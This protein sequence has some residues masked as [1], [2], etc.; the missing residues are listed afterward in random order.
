MKMIARY[1]TLPTLALAADAWNANRGRLLLSVVGVALGVALGVAV[2]LINGSAVGEFNAAARQLSGDADLSIRGPLGGFDESIYPRI[3]AMPEVDVASPAIELDLRIP[4][5]RAVHLLAV[6]PF[7]A[8]RIQPR[9]F[10]DRMMDMQRFLDPDAI[11]LSRAAADGLGASAGERITVQAGTTSFTMTIVAV[12][13]VDASSQRIAYA[14]IATAQWRLGRLGSIDRID[15]RLAPGADRR[16]VSARIASMLPPGVHVSGVDAEAQD[17][18]AMTRAYRINL[19][20]LA[21][22]ALFTG[23]FLVFATQALTILQ[24]RAEIAVLRVLGVTRGGIVRILVAES[25][26]VGAIGAALGIAIGSG[27]AWVA[28]TRFGGDLG[29]GYFSGVAIP[30]RWDPWVVALYFAL[31][32]G[33]SVAGCLLPARNAA[34]EPPAPA[35]KAADVTET[36][37]SRRPAW[38][39]LALLIIAGPLSMIPAVDD[40]PLGGYAA[41]AAVLSGAL[42]LVPFVSERLLAWLPGVRNAVAL[43]AIQQLR[44]VNNQLGIS[45]AAIV[46][47]F[48]L[49]AAM[50]I[51]IGS[52]R[53]SLERWLD[54]ILPADVYMRA[55]G[56]GQSGFIDPVALEQIA[57][58][59][60]V[61][62]WSAVRVR[63]I[64]VAADQLPLTVLA[65]DMNRALPA[66]IRGVERN[67]P[68]SNLP[69]AWITEAAADLHGW[70]PGSV[71]ELPL[72]NARVS[73]AVAG[74]WRDYTRQ[75]GAVLID[76]ARYLEATGDVRV[77]D[78]WIWLRSGKSPATLTAEVDAAFGGA[79]LVDI[80]D[81][82]TIRRFSLTMFDRTFAVTYVLEGVA[83]IIGLFGISVGFSS[84]VL[85]RRGEFGV[86]RYIGVTR[87]QIAMLLAIEGLIAGIVGIVYGL[88]TGGA[89]SV[90]LVHVINRQS[91]HWSMDMHVP[92][93]A[94]LALSAVL[95][96]A[97]T[98]TAV[99]S[100]RQAMT[101]Q[102]IAAVKDDW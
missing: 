11:L 59:P 50:L 18:V 27:L 44:G 23:S 38:P 69:P 48:S 83:V 7:Q 96:V 17:A 26:L 66:A 75:N 78:V 41:V 94:L 79:G 64:R 85:A 8:L 65:R 42:W 62:Q 37:A 47:S 10:G 30:L 29:A 74:I 54:D 86:L 28:L 93:G 70:K 31:G 95:V 55:G 77:N 32:I 90:L 82:A 98:V 49:M 25:A 63:E 46:V 84:Q 20:M 33:A 12:L 39:G 4:G 2:H 97:A 89:I 45:I 36:M 1:A 24:R 76:R 100:G 56:A 52:F 67:A 5:K 53:G 21:L 57:A 3:A 92:V 43:V 61:D 22:V 19:D 68:P 80:R 35:L 71:I 87:G 91:F 34:A 88:V 13:A 51:M 81:A 99:A 16:A 72:G 40:L 60:S 14:D 58:L 73:F 9:L 101:G 102:P 6:D 15:L